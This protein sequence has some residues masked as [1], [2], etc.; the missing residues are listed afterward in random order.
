MAFFAKLDENNV[1]LNVII[2]DDNQML[3]NGVPSEQKGID[4][5]RSYFGGT[6]IQTGPDIR[7]RS[8]HIGYIY[9][10][11]L[12]AFIPPKSFNSWILDVNE[13][14][15]VP[16]IAYPSDG[17]YYVWDETAQNWRVETRIVNIIK[18]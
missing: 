14:L 1:V 5:C 17:Q 9:N 6:W 12:N 2:I 15:Y 16:P 3:D 7:K 13:C 10:E 4:Y 8:A 18:V 11:T